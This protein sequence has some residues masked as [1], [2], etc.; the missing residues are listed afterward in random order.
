MEEIVYLK[1]RKT[2]PNS[3]HIVEHAYLFHVLFLHAKTS[4]VEIGED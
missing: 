1:R 3:K 2:R 4:E